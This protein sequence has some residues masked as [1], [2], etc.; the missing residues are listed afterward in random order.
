M[1]KQRVVVVGGN[2]AG[3]SAALELK[4]LLS[5]EVAITVISKTDKFLFVPSLI[6][7]P[8]GK[9]KPKDITFELAPVF[10]THG[11]E[12]VLDEAT[13]V[14]TAA[15]QVY[16]TQG[17]YAYDYL[18]MAS[19]FNPQFKIVPGM[20]PGKHSYYCIASLE[21]ALQAQE[22]WK[23]FVSSPGP[24]VI[25]ATQGA[26][27]F[28]AAYEFLFNFAY[29]LK[30]KRLHTKVPLTFVTP[31]P[32]AGHFG[33]GGLRGGEKMLGFFF[34][35]L[36]VNFIGGTAIQE[37]VPGEVR[38]A[39]GRILPYKY[40]MI[41]PPFYGADAV[42][43][44]TGLGDS[45]GLIPVKPNYQHTSLAN[46]YAAGAAVAVAAPWQT[47]I[48]VGVPKTGFPSEVMARVAAHN[49]A[50]EIKGKPPTEEK[51]FGDIP[52]VCVMDA[53]NMGVMIFSDK[54]L[55]PRKHELL[56]P[57][58]QAHWAKLAFEKYYLWKMKNGYVSMP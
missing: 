45:K 52:A 9:R 51:A 26:G 36:G 1:T 13:R 14:D 34:K 35:K 18:V 39:D 30:K 3:M 46:V 29:E 31:E 49:I 12:F 23:R 53:G 54:M 6:W 7:V 43:Q 24:V 27:C 20:E 10:E 41:M 32:S 37:I 33:I 17:S 16:T 42:R 57:G 8:F 56:I 5:Q 19:G 4:R 47:P 38:L 50:S 40:A 28:G 21:Q 44:S 22:G 58:P 25:G 55:P 15:Q 11:V 2:F 48:A